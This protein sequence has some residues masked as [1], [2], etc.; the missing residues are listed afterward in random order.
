MAAQ[1][2]DESAG[3]KPEIRELAL[4]GAPAQQDVGG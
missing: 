1:P 4:A 3:E 2:I